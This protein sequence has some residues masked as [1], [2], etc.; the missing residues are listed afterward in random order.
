[1][2]QTRK[3]ALQ[4]PFFFCRFSHPPIIIRRFVT[5]A[6]LL[7]MSRFC[8]VRFYIARFCL[9]CKFVRTA[10]GAEFFDLVVRVIHLN[11]TGSCVQR[12]RELIHCQR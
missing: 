6:S 11:I 1:M 9:Q 2:I 5:V 3:A 7:R 8:E 4:P 12:Y 10:F